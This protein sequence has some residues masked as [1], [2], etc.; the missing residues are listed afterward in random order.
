MPYTEFLSLLAHARAVFSDGGSNQEELSYLGVPT[1]LFR[2]RT[3]RPEGLG[4]NIVFRHSI[5]DLVE[6][7]Q[8]GAL[9]RLRVPHQL[10]A[11]AAPSQTAVDAIRRWAMQS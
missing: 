2:E 1:V 11:E 10:K 4:A 7:V 9:E 8:T 3:E 6:F 5:G